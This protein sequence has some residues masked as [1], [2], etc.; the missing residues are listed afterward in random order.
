[1]GT[2]KVK[3]L[4]FSLSQEQELDEQKLL[5]A[6]N[7]VGVLTSLNIAES[8][9]TKIT[10]IAELKHRVKEKDRENK[11]RDFIY[12]N[13]W[14]IHPRWE[15]YRGERSVK[16]LIEDVGKKRL[17]KDDAF[18]GRVDLTLS[19]GSDLLLL[20]FMKPGKKIDEDHIDRIQWYV[21]DIRNGIK[22]ETGSHIKRLSSAYII[23]DSK[24][25]NQSINTAIAELSEKG[26]YV[27]TWDTLIEQAIYQWKDHLDLLKERFPDETRIQDL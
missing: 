6:L 2:R 25:N 23:A 20:E 10:M 5:D 26:I 8:I 3:N 27:M 12:D 18:N 13:P 11:I 21:R 4:I 16:K 9:K 17:D 15:T 19:S 24:E 7:E 14:L 1:M 22:N